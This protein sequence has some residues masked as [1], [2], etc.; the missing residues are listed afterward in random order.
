MTLMLYF[1]LIL[2]VDIALAQGGLSFTCPGSYSAPNASDWSG[3]VISNNNCVFTIPVGVII[4]NC[5][6]AFDINKEL[7]MF[8]EGTLIGSFFTVKRAGAAS[9]L[10]ISATAVLRHTT[11]LFQLN[12]LGAVSLRGT[13]SNSTVVAT[14]HDNGITNGATTL[15]IKG[16]EGAPNNNVTVQLGDDGTI[17][18]LFL[19]DVVALRRPN[20]CYGITITGDVLNSS[21]VASA[22]ESLTVV[23][24]RRFIASRISAIGSSTSCTSGNRDFKLTRV[25]AVDT[26]IEYQ[27]YNLGSVELSGNVSN[28]SITIH[29]ITV[30]SGSPNEPVLVELYGAAASQNVMLL[31]V[32]N[33]ISQPM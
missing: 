16:E 18:H 19:T 15:S 7:E 30:H 8:I 27:P 1:W 28:S 13:W 26:R 24:A 32:R 10:T 23:G 9:S 22:V 21:L 12:K 31:A 14:Q 17:Q 2:H 33:R 29:Q 25:V 6:V 5:T 3:T 4:T 11:F 20:R